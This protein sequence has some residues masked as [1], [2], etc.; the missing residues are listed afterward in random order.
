M[1][2]FKLKR[3]LGLAFIGGFSALSASTVFAAAGDVISNT[4]T[5]A[6][7]VSGVA[8]TDIDSNTETFTEDLKINFTVA[9]FGGVTTTVTPSE[10]LAYQTFTVTNNGNAPQDFLFVA[11]NKAGDDFDATAVQVFV[12]TA[13]NHTG[14]DAFATATDT[15][16]FMDE[17]AAGDTRTVYIV[18]SI[19]ADA[20][21]TEV[22]NMTLIAQVAAGGAAA[23]TSEAT[24]D[25]N[26]APITNDDNN[27]T[28]PAGTYSNGNTAVAAGTGNN[29]GN[30]LDGEDTVFAEA[31]GTLNSAGAA[32]TTYNGQHS[33]DDSYTVS[34]ASLAV[35][36][37]A[38]ALWDPVNGGTNAKAIPGAY[39]QYSVT[40]TNNGAASADLTTLSDTLISTILDANLVLSTVADAT[41]PGVAETEHGATL[42]FGIKVV[43]TSNRAVNTLYC[44]GDTAA[45][46][47][48]DGCSYDAAANAV[49]NAFTVNLGTLLIVEDVAPVGAGAEDYTAG[50]L[51]PTEVVTITF[52]AIV[53]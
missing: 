48:A 4:A 8:Q 46:A 51:K 16:I 26:G 28:S 36:K 18:A 3:L 24:V 15:G 20:A 1:K 45:D 49:N 47:D 12:D 38:S 2:N 23:A 19:P 11:R 41:A 33:A 22:A 13:A 9:E 37:L 43:D 35:V 29:V 53:Q 44:T 21:D 5:L 17:L 14:T 27:H 7:T 34:S 25:D 31:A 10:T 6:Y 52:N 50:E 39:V 40:I 30:T 32:D 42:G